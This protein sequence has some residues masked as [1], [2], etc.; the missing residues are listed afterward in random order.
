MNI[1][2]SM[3]LVVNR[4]SQE[5]EKLRHL[6]EFMDVINV[7]SAAPGDWR[8]KIGEKRPE[9]IFVGADLTDSD[10]NDLLTEVGELDPNVPV[11]MMNQSSR[12]C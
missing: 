6:I 9:T 7:C 2:D 3:I 1:D 10:V 12:T 11:V 8:R 5:A 4:A